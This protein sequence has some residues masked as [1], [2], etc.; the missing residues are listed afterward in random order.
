ME[1]PLDDR[2]SSRIRNIAPETDSAQTQ[3]TAITVAFLGAKS[4]KLAKMMQSQKTSTTRNATGIELPICSNSSKRVCPKSTAIVRA[5]LR[6]D[7]CASLCG[8]NSSIL[9]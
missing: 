3:R 4:P 1:Q 2:S 5:W 7:R 6:S 9:S 8:D